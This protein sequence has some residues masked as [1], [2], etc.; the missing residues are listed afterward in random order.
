MVVVGNMF[1]MEKTASYEPLHDSNSDRP[2]NAD[3]DNGDLELSGRRPR[4]TIRL[5]LLWTFVSILFTATGIWIGAHMKSPSNAGPHRTDLAATH[6]CVEYEERKF[7]GAF[8]ADV[9][10]YEVYRDFKTPSESIYSAPANRTVDAA[11]EDLLRGELPVLFDNE[12]APFLPD[13]EKIPGKGHYYF[14]LDVYHS[15]HCLN[16]LRMRI[17]DEYYSSQQILNNSRIRYPPNWLQEHTSHCID[18]LRQSIMCH[19]DL[20]PVPLYVW[21]GFPISIG[22]SELHTCRKWDRIRDWMDER[23]KLG[24]LESA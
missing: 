10:H 9:E 7:D 23:G 4:S 22:R 8:K 3:D 6:S 18:Q 20:T 16:A 1:T 17:D 15:L 19:G 24:T 14:E 21:R 13:L 12:A 5:H 2:G 11:W